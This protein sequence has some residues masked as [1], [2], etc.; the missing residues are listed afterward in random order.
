MK[1]IGNSSQSTGKKREEWIIGNKDPIT[2][3]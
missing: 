1:N 3:D 2:I